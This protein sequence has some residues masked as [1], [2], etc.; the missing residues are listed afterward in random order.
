M[1]IF[2]WDYEVAH[3]LES[4]VATRD[5]LKVLVAKTTFIGL[6]VQF[7]SQIVAITCEARS[8]VEEAA[9][10]RGLE[11]LLLLEQSEG[12][13]E[14]TDGRRRVDFELLVLLDEAREKVEVGRLVSKAERLQLV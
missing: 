10:A 3:L 6:E 1:F 14:A 5:L 2:G 7:E 13:S 11:L 4:E 8:R 12:G 9:A